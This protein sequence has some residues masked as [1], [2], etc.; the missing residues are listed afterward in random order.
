MKRLADGYV[1]S[2]SVSRLHANFKGLIGS[3]LYLHGLI[4]QFCKY[5]DV[6]VV[7]SISFSK[8]QPQ[9][10]RMNRQTDYH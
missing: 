2:Y 6:V 1:E 4:D 8:L 5:P 3:K 9:L 7:S 10:S